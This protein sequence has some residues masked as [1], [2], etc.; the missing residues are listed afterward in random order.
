MMLADITV[1]TSGGQDPVVCHGHLKTDAI[2]MKK[3]I[4]QF[5]S[6]LY[7]KSTVKA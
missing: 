2:E 3:V 6:D 5:Q 7:G 4:E 1:E